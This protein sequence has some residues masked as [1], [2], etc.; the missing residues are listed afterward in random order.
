MLLGV[1]AEAAGLR[2]E[3]R[4]AYS[5]A[6][7]AF[8]GDASERPAREVLSRLVG[9]AIAASDIDAESRLRR[10]ARLS[11]QGEWEDAEVELR[12]ALSAART[13]PVAAEAA[14]RLGELRLGIDARAAHQAFRQAASLG[15]NVD[16]AWF[17]A[18]VAARRAGMGDATR[19]AG[20]A[21]QRV[22][23]HSE[24][25]ARWWLGAGLRAEGDGRTADAAALFR[26]AIDAA[27]ASDAAPEAR[28]RL[29][30]VALR[31]GRFDDA[32][33]RFRAAAE[34][35][36]W[37]SEAARARYWAAKT[38][39][40]SGGESNAAAAVKLLR[41]VADRY[42]LTF[43]G[44]R[45]R[46][47][48]GASAPVLPPSLPRATPRD[49]AAPVYEELRRLGFDLD[50]AEAAEDAFAVRGDPRIA[51][52]LADAYSRLG[53]IPR[54]VRHAEDALA[55]GVRDDSAWRLAY[56]RA[57]WD[58]VVAAAQAAGIDPLLLLALMREESRYDPV[59]ISPAR[60]VGLAQLLPTTAR[61]LAS[62][63]SIT[64]RRLQDPGTNLTLGARYLRLQLDR[65]SGDVRL[66]LAA[67]NAGPGAARRWVGL[68]PDPD[69]FIERIGFAETRAYIRRVLGSYGVYRL[70]YP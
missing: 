18:A 1:T 28:W 60:A 47:R 51:R 64:V 14:Y 62:D 26:R 61:A 58:E 22:A 70:L 21:L 65:F 12:A 53:D 29:G 6:A 13:G 8:P 2:A 45:A 54:S 10:G 68:D 30:W 37:R 15:W 46:A 3:A 24:W 27:P 59:V 41:L 55:R 33:A 5:R 23:P 9:R 56:P 20:A 49:A 19:E 63:A 25:A 69:Y 43:Y 7:W 36:P 32:L 40:A 42:P 11:Q 57:Y 16:A 48:L 38:L 34:A 44:Q 17:W 66:A 50:A 39:E 31:S 52:F 35:A 4:R 67:Y